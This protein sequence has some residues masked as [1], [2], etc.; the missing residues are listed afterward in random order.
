MTRAHRPPSADLWTDLPPLPATTLS[1]PPGPDNMPTPDPDGVPCCEA[2]A[3]SHD[4][5]GCTCWVAVLDVERT[6]QVQEGP[7]VIRRRMCGDCAYRPGSPER[8]ESEGDLPPYSR[9]ARF[10]CHDG[11]ARAV[12]YQHPLLGDATVPAPNDADY[13]PLTRGAQ[14][15]QADGQPA[16]LCAGWAAATGARRL[17]P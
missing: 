11:M 5:T 6:D 14:A 1:E 13:R 10:Y 12:G 15:W 16:V 8:Q 3:Y 9:A 7:H 4:G 17:A 2:T